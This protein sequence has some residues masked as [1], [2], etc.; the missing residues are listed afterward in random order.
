MLTVRICPNTGRACEVTGCMG[1]VPTLPRPTWTAPNMGWQCPKCG[2]GNAP[3]VA[4][5]VCGPA[6]TSWA[7]GT[8]NFTC[9]HSWIG[10]GEEP[11]KWTCGCGTVIYKSYEDYVDD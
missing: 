1:C 3:F 10:K 4:Q 5:C 8:A 9:T 11:K 7:S 6:Y 2:R